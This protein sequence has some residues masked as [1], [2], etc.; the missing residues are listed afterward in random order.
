MEILLTQTFCKQ[1][2]A[3]PT[4]CLLPFMAHATRAH[5]SFTGTVPC[6]RRWWCSWRA[7]WRWGRLWSSPGAGPLWRRPARLRGWA[8]RL[9]PTAPRCRGLWAGPPSRPV[10]P[11]A[12][13]WR[14]ALLDCAGSAAQPCPCLLGEEPGLTQ[15]A[16]RLALCPAHH[17]LAMQI[18]LLVPCSCR[19]AHRA[20]RICVRRQLS[21]LCNSCSRST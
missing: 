9:W 12:P 13:A 14:G 17:V 6:C 1:L 18:L 3:S 7:P 11:A 16:R 21:C 10:P 20:F 4:C 19:S 5:N 8:A 2:S 15:Q